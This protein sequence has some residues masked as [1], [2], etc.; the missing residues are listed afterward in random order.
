MTA[1]IGRQ[2]DLVARAALLPEAD[3]VESVAAWKVVHVD[4]IARPRVVTDDS[5]PWMHQVL[6][7][8]HRTTGRWSWP[9]TGFDRHE[10][11]IDLTIGDGTAAPA[12]GTVDAVPDRVNDGTTP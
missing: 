3:G 4:G 2:D 10:E 7:D 5:D 11:P 1:I 8:L 9:N 12:D 6:G